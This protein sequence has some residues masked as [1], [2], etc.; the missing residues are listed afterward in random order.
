[1]R[2]SQ[3]K[4][5]QGSGSGQDLAVHLRIGC[6]FE[7]ECLGDV[8]ALWQVRPRLD[9]L[10]RIVSEAWEP[11]GPASAY[12]DSYGNECDRLV[13]PEGRSTLRY[14]AVVEVS[15]HV[16]DV[17]VTAGQEPIE[18]LPHEA[19]LYLLPSRFCWPEAIYDEAWE[20]FGGV[21]AGYERVAAVCGWV[22]EHL[23]YEA[24]AS[25]PGTTALDVWNSRT[26]VCR[27]FAQLGL[28]LCRALN[29]PARYV[30]GYLPD[31]DVPEPDVMM[32]F[33][34]WIEVWLSGRWW[35]FDPRN[36]KPLAG[37]V[38]VAYGRDAADAAMVTTWGAAELVRMTV[39]AD[40]V[41]GAH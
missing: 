10:H 18:A 12:L 33:A 27:D 9:G 37:R 41:S 3:T 16:D 32:D 36:N 29:V 13:L 14:D 23:T 30:A 8:P 28:T 6:E 20:L 17:D 25:H 38:V 1:M 31:I 24:G 4:Q 34:S 15:G 7:Y 22:H 11:P 2:P 5:P 21:E 19:F 26:G 39:W 35:T 40:E